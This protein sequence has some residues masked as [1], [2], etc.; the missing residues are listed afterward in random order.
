MISGSAQPQRPPQISLVL[1]KPWR[2]EQ[3]Q[4]AIAQLAQLPPLHSLYQA[5]Y[6]L[7]AIQALNQPQ[8]QQLL[9]HVTEQLHQLRLQ[10][11][12]AP[13]DAKVIHR[14]IGSMG[15][16]GLLRL[17]QLCRLS[18]QQLLLQ[19][20]IDSLMTMQ[21][22]LCLEQSQAEIQILFARLDVQC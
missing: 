3:L 9:S 8:R 15:Q 10:L 12:Q 21:L 6:L 20:T 22:E 2:R 1:T 7:E 16:L 19:G 14:M 17:S 13:P 11:K 18:E 4:S 5:E